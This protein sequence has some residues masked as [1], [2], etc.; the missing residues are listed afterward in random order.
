MARSCRLPG[1]SET[2]PALALQ[3]LAWLGQFLSGIGTGTAALWAA[4]VYGRNRWHV[5]R[6]ASLE[7]AEALVR[8]P[9]LREATEQVATALTL[10][11]FPMDLVRPGSDAAR[12]RSQLSYV[13]NYLETIAQGS[14]QGFY[15]PT[16]VQTYLSGYAEAFGRRF[17]LPPPAGAD[18]VELVS[19][20]FLYL[21]LEN[22]RGVFGLWPALMP[23]PEALAGRLAEHAAAHLDGLPRPDGHRVTLER[24]GRLLLGRSEP[25]EQRLGHQILHLLGYE[26]EASLANGSR[27]AHPPTPDFAHARRSFEALAAQQRFWRAVL[28]RRA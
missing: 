5:R 12:P 3:E 2:V 17:L 19:V 11:T 14:A 4:Y 27:R 24:A 25:R 13:L 28:E 7:A 9:S 1:P 22:L 16:V 6:E 18:D 10:Q 21:P 15:S 8:D 23:A 20:R 26:D